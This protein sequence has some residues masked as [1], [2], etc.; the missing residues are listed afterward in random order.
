V[1]GLDHQ[2]LMAISDFFDQAA[3]RSAF[4]FETPRFRYVQLHVCNADIGFSAQ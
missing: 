2:N 4:R 3:N 1:A